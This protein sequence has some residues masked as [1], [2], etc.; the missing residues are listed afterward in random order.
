M[1]ALPDYLKTTGIYRPKGLKKNLP[2]IRV[3]RVHGGSVQ[4]MAGG[5]AGSV[6]RRCR[7]VR[8][9]NGRG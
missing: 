9:Q 2:A 8:K 5:F 1:D 6:T 3:V 7:M 4:K